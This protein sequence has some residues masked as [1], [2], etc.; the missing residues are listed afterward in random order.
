MCMGQV[1]QDSPGHGDAG[2]LSLCSSQA[3]GEQA[4]SAPFEDENSYV[5]NYVGVL[6]SSDLGGH[7]QD[8]GH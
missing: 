2:L 3:A 7:T 8:Q 6:S 4:I 5:F 1:K